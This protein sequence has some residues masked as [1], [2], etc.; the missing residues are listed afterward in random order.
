MNI[1][2]S[3][4]AKYQIIFSK[5]TEQV[6]KLKQCINNLVLQKQHDAVIR[7]SSPALLEAWNQYQVLRKLIGGPNLND[8]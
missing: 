6:V 3:S 8:R 4:S 2:Y 1:D 5:D 7:E